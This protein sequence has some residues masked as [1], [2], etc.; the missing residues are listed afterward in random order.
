M[1]DKLKELSEIEL[2]SGLSKD[3]LSYVSE[4]CLTRTFRKGNVLFYEGEEA[5]CLYVIVEGQ[6]EI[7]SDFREKERDLLAISSEKCIVGEMALIDSLPR[8]ATLIAASEVRTYYIDRDSYE[9]IILN[10]PSIA[11]ILMKSLSKI[12]RNSNQ[13]YVSTLR[14]QNK[15]IETTYKE[16]IATQEKL[17][18]EEKLATVGQFS[19]MILHDIRNPVSVI[20]SYSELALK[21]YGA[22]MDNNL[23]KYFS[24]IIGETRKLNFLA[25]DLL[26]FSKGQITLNFSII[27]VT[28][29]IRTIL[30]DQMAALNAKSINVKLDCRYKGVVLIDGERFERVI[31]NLI[32]NARK[33]VAPGG[34]IE[35]QTWEDKDILHMVFLDN[36]SGMSRETLNHLFEPFYSKS[37]RGTGLGMIIIKNI[38]EVHDGSVSVKSREGEG[39]KVHLTLPLTH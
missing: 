3:D 10:C 33:A 15:K 9:K 34:T 28:S 37:D 4:F 35:I 17:H 29:F 31:I 8:S 5:D 38:V 25:A 12:V 18:Q 1:D 11:V 6:V 21:K 27:E 24:H 23:I 30:K 22:E 26:D 14:E 7:W 39:T 36:G 32:T 13:S 19:S 16:L 20:K 2:F